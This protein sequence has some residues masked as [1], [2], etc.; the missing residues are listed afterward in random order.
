MSDSLPINEIKHTLLAA[1]QRHATIVLS[2]PPGAGKSTCL[3]LWL[4]QQSEWLTGTIY[5]LQPRRVAVKNIAQY[6]AQQLGEAVGKTV[7]Y[8]LRSDV[9]VSAST[10]LEVITEAIL[11][12]L[13][14][15]NPELEQCSLVIFDEFHERSSHGDLAFALARDIQQGLRD[16][17][18]ILLMS[19]TLANDELIQQLPDAV[20]ISSAGRSFAVSMDYQPAPN[21]A[22][23]RAHAVHVIQQQALSHQGSILV[24][25][26]GVAD[27]RYVITQLVDKLPSDLQL[28]PLYGDLSLAEQ[29]RVIAP[30]PA[31]MRKLVLATNIAETSITIDGISLVIDSGLEKVAHFN[32]A[33]LMT[34]LVQQQITQS[35]AIQ[36]AGRAGRLMAGHCIRLYSD[37]DFQRRPKQAPCELCHTDLLPVLIEVAR[38]GVNNMAALP[39]LTL[40]SESNQCSAWAELQQFGI[41]NEQH[42]LTEHG[43]RVGQLRCHPRLAQ[44]IIYAQTLE[45]QHAILQLTELACLLAALVEERDWYRA[46]QARFDCNIVHRV[47]DV[48]H[49]AQQQRNQNNENTI[50]ARIIKQYRLLIQQCQRPV[51]LPTEQLPLT[52]SGA[53]LALAYPERVAKSRGKHGEFIT[54]AGKG[55]TMADE[56]ALAAE[57]Y[58]VAANLMHSQQRLT[59]RLAAPFTEVQLR[60]YFTAQLNARNAL[61]F[62]ASNGKIIAREQLW[63][64]AILVSEQPNK[65]APP[66]DEIAALWQQLV[67]QHGLNF[68]PWQTAD[69]ALLSRWRWVNEFVSK[70][71]LPLVDEQQLIDQLAIWFTPFVG[72]ITNIAQL[73]KQSLSTMLLSL[74]DYSQ[75][76]L[77]GALA[78]AYFVGPTGRK[79]PISYT[80][81]AS[82]TV[83]LPMQELYGERQTPMVGQWQQQPGI[84]LLLELLSPAGRPIQITQNLEAF[85]QGSYRQ[86]QKDMKAQYPKHRW[87]DNPL[88]APPGYK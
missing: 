7:G 22:R 61:Q 85:W 53:L 32:R 30:A 42:K 79:C 9:K 51:S 35:S 2:A 17:L 16:D 46:E 73:A 18:K 72:A 81:H 26:P 28:A 59:V 6:L 44:M 66:A 67:M 5:L 27:I 47:I 33:S 84:P 52:E 63:L 31:G 65:T 54:Q 24:F 80:E 75:Q 12:Q 56:D 83:S 49:Y 11:T 77:L 34:H 14:Q 57:P 78:P 39:F 38:W 74:L 69:L 64:G 37:D 50:L 68:L 10:R 13:M 45:Q 40:P 58:I 71:P 87:P 15:Q 70:A 19:A 76:Q 62:D 43:Q 4:L 20:A 8:R 29:Q 23:W 60:R 86:V 25:L 88:T 21:Y 41:V 48:C 55:C 82:P 3:P 1:L 36:R